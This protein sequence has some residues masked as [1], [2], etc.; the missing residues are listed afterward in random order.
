[1][2]AR[3]QFAR[4]TPVWD[5]RTMPAGLRRAHRLSAGTWGRVEVH[6]G[7]LHFRAS[8]TPELV[9]EL[10]AGSSQAIPPEVE[11]H[12]EPHGAVRFTVAFLTVVRGAGGAVA[13][14]FQQCS[15]P[16]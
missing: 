2:P 14:G 9:V 3:V 8:T 10:H 4:R 16:T 1:M 11:H 15:G 13:T 7:A 5:E 12:V 6:R